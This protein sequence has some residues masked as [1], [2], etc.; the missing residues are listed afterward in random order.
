[1]KILLTWP[2]LLEKYVPRAILELILDY[3]LSKPSKLC[4]LDYNFNL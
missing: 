1:M 3:N 2:Y 4:V